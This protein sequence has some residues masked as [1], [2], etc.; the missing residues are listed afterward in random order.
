MKALGEIL[1]GFVLSCLLIGLGAFWQYEYNENTDPGPRG[2]AFN[3]QDIIR[4][5][6]VKLEVDD[7]T[8]SATVGYY[9]GR[10]LVLSAGHILEKVGKK[11]KIT[12]HRS[13]QDYTLKVNCLVTDPVYDLSLA[14][15]DDGLPPFVY[16]DLTPAD[17]LD[18]GEGFI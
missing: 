2:A 9:K 5:S 17:S 10:F 12:V 8:G 4:G 15:V 1:C 13:G 18:E 11:A 14:S 16:P 7:G 6:S 3:T